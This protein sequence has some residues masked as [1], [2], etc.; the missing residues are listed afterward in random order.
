MDRSSIAHRASD[1]PPHHHALF[2]AL[3]GDGPS[4]PVP[5]PRPRLRQGLVLLSI[6]AFG[7]APLGTA[8]VQSDS[9]KFLVILNEGQ[10]DISPRGVSVNN[11][12]LILPNGRVHLERRLQQLP[13]S[14]ATLEVFESSL[15]TVLSRQLGEILNDESVK[16][17]PPFVW[18]ATPMMGTKFRGFK[19][20]ITRGDQ[21]QS[22]GYFTGPEATPERRLDSAPNTISN[23]IRNRWKESAATLRP[24]L[25]WLQGLEAS[26]LEPSDRKSTL[27]TTDGY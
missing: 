3:A 14:S 8:Q 5:P 24:L 7:C 9:N 25:Q 6:L 21:V 4:S 20:R 2:T 17:L 11:C 27:C 1:L 12:A 15:D 23:D 22:V 19:A 13:N 10:V 16:K 18:P 26:K